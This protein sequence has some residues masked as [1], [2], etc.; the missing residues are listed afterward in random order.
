MY[1]KILYLKAKT[2]DG[3]LRQT[4]ILDTKGIFKLIE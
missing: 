1:E 3:K 4:D 2:Q